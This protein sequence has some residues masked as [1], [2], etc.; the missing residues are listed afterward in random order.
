MGHSTDSILKLSKKLL[1][2]HDGL[3]VTAQLL[4][5]QVDMAPSSWDISIQHWDIPSLHNSI[6]PGLSTL[7]NHAKLQNKEAKT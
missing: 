4:W 2:Q 6:H 5:V 1:Y 3:L 7:I